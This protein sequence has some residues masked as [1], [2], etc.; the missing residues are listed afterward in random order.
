MENLGGSEILDYIESLRE[1]IREHFGGINEARLGVRSPD[2]IPP[3]PS[4]LSV[5]EAVKDSGLP[6]VS[7]GFIDQPWIWN[8]IFAVVREELR[9][10][11]VLEDAA[12]ATA[13]K[14]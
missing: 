6:L 11:Q 9:I 12:N 13:N 14:R 3:R 2:K 10:Q 1:G 8:E 7:G 5:Y 4:E